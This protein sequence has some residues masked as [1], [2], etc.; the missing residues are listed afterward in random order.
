V[1][2]LCLVFCSR[3]TVSINQFHLNKFLILKI[4][5]SQKSF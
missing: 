4:I 2:R 1:C 3:H 5:Y